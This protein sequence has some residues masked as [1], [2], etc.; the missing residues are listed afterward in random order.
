MVEDSVNTQVRSYRSALKSTHAVSLNSLTNTHIKL[1]S[2]LHP[3]AGNPAKIDV[4]AFTYALLR[5]P[6]AVD[7]AR[8]VIAAPT[9]EVFS[10]AGFPGVESWPEVSSLHRRRTM[11]FSSSKHT[12]ACFISS[13]SDVDDLTNLLLA[14]QIE[15][16]KLHNLL[17]TSFPDKFPSPAE[18]LAKADPDLNSLK[19]ALGKNWLLRLKTI[20]RRPQNLSLHLLSGS[21]IDYTKAAQRWWKNIAI[22]TSP[23]FHVSHQTIYF[24]SSNNHSLFNIFTGLPL[25]N[26]KLII[27]HLA[28]HFPD[29][30]QTWL[31]VESQ[32]HW[33]S[34]SDFLYFASQFLRL[35]PQYQAQKLALSEKLHLL[36]IPNPHYLNVTVQ[37]F[38][39]QNLLRSHHHHPA[40]KIKKPLKLSRS[41]AYIFNIDYPLGLTAYNLLTEVLENVALVKGIYILGKAAV[42]NA[43]I[44][45]IHI[46]RLVFDEPTGNT[47]IFKNCFNTFFPFTTNKSS[48]IS[49]QKAV[50][51]LGTYLE[52]EEVLKTY[53][54]NNLNIIE[55]ESGPYLGA[56]AEATYDQR[57]PKDTIIDLNNAPF[58][59]GIINYASDTP[60]SQTKNLGLRQLSLDGVEPTY[61]S[62]LTILQRIIELEEQTY[63]L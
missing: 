16:N 10:T 57:L 30:Y 37:I 40:L 39:L 53:S 17:K 38:P 21:W 12:L 36:N 41:P 25:Q 49:E 51:V 56:V 54:Q 47:Y 5:L 43:E 8:L 48:V 2:I 55:M 15:W 52:N 7:R 23:R 1:N 58:D 46:P 62:T 6:H 42:L 11:H 61:L 59:I 33:L 13:I 4:P 50:S 9:P 34:E 31:R 14:Y 24:V 63:R 27:D 32:D 45:D 19:L 22:T 3:L 60:Y 35:N 18:A 20:Y 29:L 44:G 26:K 28:S